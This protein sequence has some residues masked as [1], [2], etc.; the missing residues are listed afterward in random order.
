MVLNTLASAMSVSM[1]ENR[2]Q[3]RFTTVTIMVIDCSCALLSVT[4]LK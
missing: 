4:W 2:K 1:N 3:N